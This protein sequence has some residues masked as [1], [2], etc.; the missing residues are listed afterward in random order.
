MLRLAAGVKQG[1]PCNNLTFLYTAAL[2][3]TWR[4]VLK[5]NSMGGGCALNAIRGKK[6]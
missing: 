1:A 6:R 4:A 2:V 5:S 3:V